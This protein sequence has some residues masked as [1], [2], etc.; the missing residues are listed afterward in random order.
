MRDGRNWR[1][2]RR[3]TDK[4]NIKHAE[5]EVD[6]CLWPLRWPIAASA[7]VLKQA[8][9]TRKQPYNLL[10]YFDSYFTRWNYVPESR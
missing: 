3:E 10:G 4:K 9:T 6:F 8:D 2:K 7:I 1:W 5:H